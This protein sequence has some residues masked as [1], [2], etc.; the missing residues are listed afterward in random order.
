MLIN[1]E[2]EYGKTYK[3][4]RDENYAEEKEDKLIQLRINGKGKQHIY[5]GYANGLL[6]VW[7]EG[8]KNIAKCQALGFVS[9][10]ICDTEA[11]FG[12]PP[13]YLH[14][15]AQLIKAKRKKKLTAAHLARLTEMGN[16][17]LARINSLRKKDR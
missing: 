13:E 14:K 11:T 6:G 7:V 15:V 12:F 8:R 2:K 4:E 17:N 3:V 10:Q 5:A 16:R 9:E 1:L